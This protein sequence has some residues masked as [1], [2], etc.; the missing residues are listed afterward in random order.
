MTHSP[1]LSR[2]A[3]LLAPLPGVLTGCAPRAPADC[4][5]RPFAEVPVR[6][7]QASPLVFASING[8]PVTML[9][10]TGAERT[11]LTDEAAR[12]AGLSF[13]A[14]DVRRASGAG[15]AVASFAAQVR[16]FEFGGLSIP[17]HPV[18]A[19]PRPLPAP[20]GERI[21]GLL[22]ALVLSAFDVDLDL[23][24][25]R[26]TLYGGTVCG[27]TP[28]PPWPGAHAS[29][30]A[31]FSTGSRVFVLARVGNAPVRALLDTGAQR[32]VIAPRAALAAGVTPADFAGAPEARVRGIGAETVQ[33]RVVRVP[34]VE[35]GPE[36]F[37]AMP[38]LATDSGLGAIDMVLGMDYLG[39]RRLWLSYAR[40]QVF[41]M[42]P[43]RR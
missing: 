26:M 14:R 37:G 28:I 41:I 42:V 1:L 38:M 32:T 8:A 18:V 11:L 4:G 31:E 22:P 9:L 30:P 29:V 10:D 23:P 21:D 7:V 13:D 16:R 25:G 19:S 33:A 35:I 27:D 39:T 6:V 40:R 17:D 36:R 15:G 34:S 12:R 20:P 3:A 2:R 43:P 24:G 5:I